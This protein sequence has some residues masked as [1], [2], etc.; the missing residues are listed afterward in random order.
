M[1]YYKRLP[2][3][4]SS[5]NIQECLKYT[6]ITFLP[7]FE[8][9]EQYIDVALYTCSSFSIVLKTLFAYKTPSYIF[10]CNVIIFNTQGSVS[11]KAI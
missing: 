11:L 7:K 8:N 9:N 2:L 4:I 6:Q 1:A 3:P 10:C 5:D